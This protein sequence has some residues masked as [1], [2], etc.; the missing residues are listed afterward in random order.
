MLV[1][2]AATAQLLTRSFGRLLAISALIGVGA[3][4]IG[5]HVSYWANSA[6]GATIVLVET[7]AF[8]VAVVIGRNGAMRRPRALQGAEVAEVAASGR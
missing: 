4:V 3:P 1:T 2:P 5:L 7:A 8:L 6:S